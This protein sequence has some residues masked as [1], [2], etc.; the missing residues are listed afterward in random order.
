MPIYAGGCNNKGEGGRLSLHL[1]KEIGLNIWVNKSKKGSTIRI[2]LVT[3]RIFVV[4]LR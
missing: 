3:C 1:K 4:E 2:K